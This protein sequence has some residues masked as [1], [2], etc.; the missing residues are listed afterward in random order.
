MRKLD[1]PPI[2]VDF[3]ELR[4]A[5]E[6][7]R[8]DELGWEILA[9]AGRMVEQVVAAVERATAASG[10][11]LD[12]AVVGGLLVRTSKLLRGVFDA[13]RSE[14]SEAHS[15]LSRCALE[16]AIT[17]RWLVRKGTEESF[18]RFRADSFAYWRVQLDAMEAESAREDATMRAAREQA[19]AH[20]EGELGLAGLTWEDVPRT[21]NS[22][23]PDMRQRCAAL[24]QEWIYLSFFASHHNYVHPSWHELSTFHLRTDDGG[25]LRLAPE[26]AEIAP[27]AAYVLARAVCEAASDAADFLPHDLDPE[28]VKKRLESTVEASQW[29]AVEFSDYLTRG[30]F[31]RERARIGRSPGGPAD[32]ASNAP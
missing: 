20:I 2:V 14:E 29:L 4:N 5:D 13:T 15:A 18:R 6:R 28:D 26:F 9:R 24:E 32:A 11:T 16:S 3:D 22:W 30:G 31:E 17:L 12:Q 1:L 27:I 10:L 19:H 23:G 7:D 21:P 8:F 25:V